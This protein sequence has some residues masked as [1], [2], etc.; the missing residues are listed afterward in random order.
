MLNRS[1]L[2]PPCWTAVYTCSVQELPCIA[3]EESNELWQAH[4][5]FLKKRK[6]CT[7][8]NSSRN[9][10]R[11]HQSMIIMITMRTACSSVS[12]SRTLTNNKQAWLGPIH[13]C[14]A[15]WPYRFVLVSTYFTG[16]V[17]V[18][19][20]ALQKTIQDSSHA[21][22]VQM[23]NLRTSASHGDQASRLPAW[24]HDKLRHVCLFL[25]KK[26]K[27]KNFTSFGQ[28]TRLRGTSTQPSTLML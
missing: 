27:K 13:R 7:H 10:S 14:L 6:T 15:L 25:R 21:C 17:V 8:R 20:M 5:W 2:K 28:P 19:S 12:M 26:K 22:C 18:I 24:E 1:V 4:I 3:L 16:Q 11:N 23:F 9:H